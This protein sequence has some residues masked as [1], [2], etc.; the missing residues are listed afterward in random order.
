M[1]T[2]EKNPPCIRGG[3]RRENDSARILPNTL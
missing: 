3:V 1:I 2:P